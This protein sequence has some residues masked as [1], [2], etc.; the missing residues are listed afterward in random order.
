[1][2][3]NAPFYFYVR[4]FLFKLPGQDEVDLDDISEESDDE[5]ENN[6]VKVEA[7][8]TTESRTGGQSILDALPE[9]NMKVPSN[10]F[11]FGAILPL[12]SN[13]EE[14]YLCYK[15]NACSDK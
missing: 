2:P 13:I 9:I 8:S 1:M 15:V 5:K 10:H 12:L 7:K 11:D 14:I 3:C 6:V 4:S